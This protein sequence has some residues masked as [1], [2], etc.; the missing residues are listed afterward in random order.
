MDISQAPG[1]VQAVVLGLIQGLSEFLPISS[2][3][4][5]V[6]LPTLT[7]WEHMGK[8][9]DVA[10]HFGTLMAIIAYYRADVA[11]LF[12]GL[13]GLL[14]HRLEGTPEELAE[15]RLVINLGVA[16]IPAGVVGLALHDVLEKHFDK[17]GS[18]AIFLALFGLLM[19]WAERRG[20]QSYEISDLTPHAAG[21]LG[22]AQM[23]ALMP[24][25]SRS[26]STMTM[27][28]LL[29]LKRGE[30]ARFSFLMALPVTAAA[31]LLKGLKLIKLIGEGGH[32]QLL[33][34]CAIGIAVSAISGWLCIHFLM[35]Y[36]RTN[37]FTPFVIYRLLLA[38]FLLCWMLTHG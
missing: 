23:L 33:I 29:G 9:F 5:L 8:E 24:G 14:R 35:R 11:S 4:H 3:G 1:W 36:L 27:G 20:S 13:F 10:L 17:I 12:R 31:C 2:S 26:G 30:A 28:L 21:A 6:L 22:L 37:T 25:V 16:S 18:I 38:A 7:G 19:G 32:Q 15:R 34:N